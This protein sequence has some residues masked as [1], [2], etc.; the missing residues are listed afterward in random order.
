MSRR[1]VQRTLW[2]LEDWSPDGCPG[3]TLQVTYD[4]TVDQVGIYKDSKQ[5]L[6]QD[7]LFAEVLL[8]LLSE[9]TTEIQ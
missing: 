2:C 9:V 3:H 1:T 4:N 5:L 7:I 8:A 6:Y